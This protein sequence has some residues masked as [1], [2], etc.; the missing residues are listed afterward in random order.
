MEDE[1][2][3]NDSGQRACPVC[4]A[5]VNP[6]DRFCPSCGSPR[7]HQDLDVPS[8]IVHHEQPTAPF[9][10]GPSLDEPTPP[11]PAPP[12]A[13]L[14]SPGGY[15]QSSWSSAP[16]PPPKQGTNRTWWIIGGIFVFFLLVCCCCAALVFVTASQDSVLQDEIEGTA[17][18]LA[19]FAAAT[20]RAR[21]D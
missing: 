18:L 1:L 10:S 5:T 11:P 2:S 15:A 17:L 8:P 7:A 6:D 3:M 16:P 13:P 12:A 4:G 19:A 21:N 14:Y 20:D 9:A